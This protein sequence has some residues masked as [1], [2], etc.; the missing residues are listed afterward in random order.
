MRDLPDVLH[1]LSVALPPVLA[2]L[3]V[4]RFFGAPNSYLLVN[5]GAFILGTVALMFVRAPTGGKAVH[6]IASAALALMAA[7]LVMG[8]ELDGIR[9]WIALGPVALNTGLVAVPVLAVVCARGGPVGVLTF[10]CATL[11]LT[12]QPDAAALLALSLA[13]LTMAAVGKDWRFG[14][15]GLL[16]LVGAVVRHTNGVPDPVPFVEGVVH[17]V[18]SRS[19]L[20]GLALLVALAVPVAALW[21][22]S[23]LDRRAAIVLAASYAGFCLASLT[24]DYP[25]PLTGYGASAIIGF[26]LALALVPARSKSTE[27]RL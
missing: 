12:L 25:L 24:N 15:I 22:G 26:L 10:A 5:A 6:W 20:S 18:W 11:I 1:R 2:G 19:L 9:R 14:L 27:Q 7:P 13:G 21:R 16:C 17:M 23:L 3:L 4:F 8:H